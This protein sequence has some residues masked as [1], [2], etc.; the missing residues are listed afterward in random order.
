M[1]LIDQHRAF[2]GEQR[3][4]RHKAR[5]LDC[6]MTFSVFLPPKWR[7]ESPLLYWLSG[8]TCTDENFVQKAGAQRA[9]AALGLV[10]VAPDTSPRGETV[11]N[12]EAYDLGQG[13][14]FYVNATEEPWSRHYRMEDYIVEELPAQ[15]RSEL[16]LRGRSGI[17]GHSMGGHGA[18]SLALKHP[19]R[20]SSVSAFAPIAN[21]SACPWGEKA[22]SAYL[23]KNRREWERHDS[24]V[25]LA[26]HKAPWPIL[27]DVGSSDGFLAEQLRPEALERAALASGSEVSVRRREGYDHSYFFVASFMDEHLQFHADQLTTRP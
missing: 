9:A 18:I 13:A 11:A 14:G 5:S 1:E 19:E 22:F 3:R 26:E 6:D 27:V 8:L 7:S 24:A 21:P 2:D 17:S 15:L 23:G 16:G 12:D 10:L 25:L 20:Y 4:Y